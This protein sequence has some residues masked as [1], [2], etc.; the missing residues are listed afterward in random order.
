MRF[1]LIGMLLFMVGMAS[2]SLRAADLSIDIVPQTSGDDA[3]TSIN[4]RHTFQ[5]VLTN[6]SNHSLVIWNDACS[7]GYFNLSFEFAGAN[8]HVI[9]VERASID[10]TMNEPEGEVLPPG[11]HFVLL[12]TFRNWD[13][14]DDPNWVHTDGL[15]GK[16][17]MKA[18]YKNTNAAFP[19]QKP[20][21]KSEFLDYQ[22]KFFDLAWVGRIESK[23]VEVTFFR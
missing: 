18:I 10:F 1:L 17:A 14:K 15:K 22:R 13:V 20:S 19:G 6:T 2:V 21:Q 8:G 7:W 5:F 9:K 23:P 4:P 16:M 12:V 11:K 3:K